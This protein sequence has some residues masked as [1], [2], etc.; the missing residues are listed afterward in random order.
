[1]NNNFGNFFKL[2]RIEKNLTQKQLADI[3]YVSESAVSK[4]EKGV[5]HPDISLLP[6]IAEIL[7]VSEHEL[8]TASVDF[9]A[10]T[11]KVQAKKWRTLSFSWSLFF[12]ISYI[13][14]LIPCFICDLAINKTLSWFWIVL[15]ALLLAFCLTNLPGLVKKHKLLILPAS[16]YVALVLLL[17]VCA[18]Y[19]K[20]D[21]F[22][23]PTVAILFAMITVFLPIYISK[24][25]VFEKIRK[26][27]DFISIA[28][29][30]VF[31]N[32]LLIIIDN[33]CVVNGYS[34][35]HWYLTIALPIT[36]I[37]YMLLNIMMSVRFLK[38]NK[39]IKT[40]LILFFI[41]ILYLVIPFIKIKYKHLQEELQDFNIFKA[42]LSSWSPELTLEPNINLIIFLTLLGI[43]FVLLI[44][45]KIKHNKKKHKSN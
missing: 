20:G 17:G 11:D 44:F 12:Y 4:W 18:I 1:M 36:L 42:N 27:N 24:Y 37:S 2:K 29:D 5:A 7:E 35:N 39:L 13:I 40:S 28:M 25:K 32:L 30:F 31:L 9:Q 41:N 21:W 38:V 34:S 15:A 26:Y 6:K 33:Y 23:I 14:T 8:I 10:R 45:G 43:A 3:L 22:I 16:I 19:S